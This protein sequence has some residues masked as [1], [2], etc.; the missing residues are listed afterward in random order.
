MDVQVLSSCLARMGEPLE[1]AL[2]PDQLAVCS[3]CVNNWIN[4]CPS[5]VLTFDLLSTQR[6]KDAEC[7][8]KHTDLV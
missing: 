3:H 4:P 1:V 7:R 2:T 8:F 6:V 5:A